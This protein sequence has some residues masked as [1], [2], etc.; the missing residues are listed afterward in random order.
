[1]SF[2]VTPQ[3]LFAV[4]FP[5]L[6]TLVV[7]VHHTGP[8][9]PWMLHTALMPESPRLYYPIQTER[10]ESETEYPLRVSHVEPG[11]SSAT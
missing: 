1:M 6:Q 8:N 7:A 4:L 10:L 5:P 9:L 2:F 3:L 11:S